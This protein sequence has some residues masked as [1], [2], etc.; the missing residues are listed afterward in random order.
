MRYQLKRN[1]WYYG[2]WGDT[3]QDVIDHVTK[4]YRRPWWWLVICGW[5]V[6]LENAIG[7]DIQLEGRPR[8]PTT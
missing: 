2:C 6:G 8:E 4:L 3:K 5:E 7:G 1:G